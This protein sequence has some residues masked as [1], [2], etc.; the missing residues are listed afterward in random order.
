[1]IKPFKPVPWQAWIASIVMLFHAFAPV[2]AQAQGPA[3]VEVCSVTGSKFV[4]AGGAPD[5][6]KALAHALSHCQHCCCQ[7]LG[8]PLPVLPGMGFAM[9]QPVFRVAL[10]RAVLVFSNP[11]FSLAQARAPPLLLS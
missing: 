8:P 3:L 1:M 10:P 2:W 4:A 6:S 9:P 5:A 11:V 7:V